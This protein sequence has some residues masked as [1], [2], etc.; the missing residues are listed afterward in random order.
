MNR[1]IYK[2]I[3]LW[4]ALPAGIV[5]F[6]TC[7]TGAILVFKDEWL[8]IGGYNSIRESPLLPV[9]QLHRWLMDETRTVGKIIVGISTLFFIFILL[10][11]IRLHSPFRKKTKLRINFCKN[12]N[13]LLYDCHTVIG[14]YSS[15]ILIV[16]SLTGLMWSFQW[17]REAVGYLFNADIGRGAPIW[18]VIKAL[19]FG[20]YAGWI[21]KIPTFIASMI[22]ASLPITG[23]WL[24]LKKQKQKSI[25]SRSLYAAFTKQTDDPV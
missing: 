22:G 11:G 17:Y 12:K 1:K 6:I 8:Q 5:I 7:L 2:K 21:S 3:H 9:M 20:N 10:S 16:C 4:L 14:F 25:R 13:R 24:Y 23:Y 15:I 19:H 18:E